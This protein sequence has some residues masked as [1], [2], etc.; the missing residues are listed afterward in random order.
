MSRFAAGEGGC[1]GGGEIFVL[2]IALTVLLLLEVLPSAGAQLGRF[3]VGL[4][5]LDELTRL[6]LADGRHLWVL[7]ALG[8]VHLIGGAA[9]IVGIWLPAV[10]VAG[11][12][13]EAAVFG[14]VLFRQLRAGDRGGALFAY[15]LFTSMA[16]AVL[17]VDALR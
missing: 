16:L 6:G 3:E 10:G 11:A 12:A 9:V 17:V 7:P 2:S 5:R 1:R 8:T 13:L 14:W 4:K 15:S